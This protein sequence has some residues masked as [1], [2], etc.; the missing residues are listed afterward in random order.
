[1]TRKEKALLTKD[2]IY[3]CTLQLIKEKGY[4]NVLIDDITNLAGLAKGSFYNHF[5][6]KENLLFYTFQCA[7]QF[8]AN[9]LKKAK[10]KH[11]FYDLLNTFLTLSYSQVEKL[12]KEIIRAIY[13]NLFSEEGRNSF[14]NKN[15]C[16]YSSLIYIVEY[17]KEKGILNTKYETDYYVEKIVIAL[18]GIDSYWSLI[19]EQRSLPE[20][21]KEIVTVIM[22]GFA[23]HS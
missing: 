8:Y 17:G 20:L 18:V 7:D 12:G 6:S 1:M 4:S 3:S 2:R 23:L 22:K 19:E 21:A 9:A 13:T 11:D 14:L 16:L 5:Q 15:R 10:K